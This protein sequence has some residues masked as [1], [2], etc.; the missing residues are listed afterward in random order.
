M[1]VSGE[2]IRRLPDGLLQQIHLARLHLHEFA[3]G[4]SSIEPILVETLD[5]V[6]RLTDS[7][8]GFYHFYDERS[9]TIT[10]QAWSTA[11]KREF[12]RAEGFGSHYPIARAGVWVDGIRERRAVIHNDYASLPHRKGLPPGHAEVTRELVVP[13]FR[14]GRIVAILGVGNK[15][16]D[17][18]E[19][20][21]TIVSL[22]ADLAW[23]VANGAISR[24]RMAETEKR[25]ELLTNTSLDAFV[26]TDE[27]LRILEASDEACRLYGY[28]RSELVSL[29][30][31]DIEAVESPEET[32][33]HARRLF[34]RRYDRFETRHCRKD[35]SEIEIEASVSWLPEQS[36]F[37]CFFRDI[38]KRKADAE[39]LRDQELWL[40][41]SQAVGG[42]GCYRYDL[43]S[44]SWKGTRALED[45]FGIAQAPSHPVD[46]WLEVVHPD[47]RESMAD[48][49]S[50]LVRGGGLPFDREYRI[51][52]PADGRERWVHGRGQFRL[53]E[54]GRPATLIGTIIDT[55]ERKRA[56]QALE[57][58][59]RR[60]DLALE[61]GGEGVW[62][63][64]F[65]TGALSWDAR[66]FA[67]YGTDPARFRGRYEDWIERVHPDDRDAA[68]RAVRDAG[69]G[70][71]PYD[72]EFRI[73]RPDGNCRHVKANGVIV[74]DAGGK[75]LRMIG[76]N[77]DV[78]EHRRIEEKLSHSQR[79]D[80]I[81]R[82]AGGVAHD[83][84]NVLQIMVG[85]AQLLLRQVPSGSAE[86]GELAQIIEAGERGAAL[87]R[88]LLAFSRKQTLSR[89]KVDLSAL[90]SESTRLARRLVEE[91]I[92]LEHEG[93]PEPLPV[94]VDPALVQ[95]AFFNLVT[96]ARDATGRH[97]TIRVRSFPRRI[98]ADAILPEV[99][100][101]GP[102]PPGR[103]GAFL[104]S[105][106]GSGISPELLPRMFEPFF[107]TK[108]AG[109][110]TGLGLPMT[111]GTVVQ[112]GGFLLV[113]STPGKGSTFTV[114]FPL[115][116]V[117]GD[118]GS[119]DERAR[120]DVRAPGRPHLVL[121]VEDDDSVR[122]LLVT[123][124]TGAG[125]RVLAAADGG[126]AIE[127][128]GQRGEE[129]ELLLLDIVMP[130]MGGPET[131]AR[132]HEIRPGL[133]VIFLS[134]YE[135]GFLKKERVP[136]DAEVL[137][138]PIDMDEL[139]VRIGSLLGNAGTVP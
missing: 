50:E 129:V 10:L 81:G 3:N 73:V 21:V 28:D 42:F 74:R 75:A 134:G 108:E 56:E 138:K 65:A 59:N 14:E 82:L 112:H 136:A 22:M 110:G 122:K 77:R 6:E 123:V 135:A 11:T 106:G 17:Y 46:E 117:P 85:N 92:R 16:R 68:A 41:E 15:A 35:G 131:C 26:V 76:I 116:E 39:M 105:D 36:R 115:D 8:I 49:L 139:L 132:I 137:T 52:R 24:F 32:A 55:T 61:A 45:I 1:M 9:E 5:Q 30:I 96:N 111:H 87:T 62:D 83:I 13:V 71:A 66:M 4:V 31:P 25:Y 64:D 84:N 63:Y 57:E 100:L 98:V 43:A 128:F 19:E 119:S 102:V 133:P 88:A 20:D 12:C 34:E 72:I 2:S 70:S 47:D 124:L 121:V 95:H 54:T 18:G 103:Y 60:L 107:T 126:E 104:V 113:D 130:V 97:G 7:R 40:R 29:R 38:G 67:L 89:R 91:S 120:Q 58:A 94:F 53:D 118:P 27:G 78:T 80:A 23:D 79:M 86:S 101:P 90:V 114:L 125:Y 37:F 48:Y 109:K 127:L 44:G 69:D 51:L 33:E 93:S 99:A